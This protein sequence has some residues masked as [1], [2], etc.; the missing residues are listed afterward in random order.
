MTV[1]DPTRRGVSSYVAAALL[2]AA[3]SLFAFPPVPLPREA[4]ILPALVLVAE[5]IRVPLAGGVRLSFPLPFLA[6]IAVVG[7]PF[8]ALAVDVGATLVSGLVP[9][10]NPSRW[11]LLNM[12]IAAVSCGGSAAAFAILGEA[13]PGLSIAALTMLFCFFYAV[14]NTVLV[15]RVQGVRDSRKIAIA[16]LLRDSGG[17]LALYALMTV[18]VALFVEESNYGLVPLVLL[19]V[20]VLRALAAH[21]AKAFEQ[22]CETISALTMMLQRAHP[23][24]HGHIERVARISEDVA[25]RLG[26][27]PERARLVREASVLHDIGK[28]A[29]D[30]EILDKPAKLTETEMN[31]VRR[32]AAFGATILTP[33]EPFRQIVPWIRH[34]HERPDGRGYPAGL[35]D[36]EIPLESKIIAVVDAFDAM[37]GGD[38]P[39]ERRPYRK[40]MTPIQALAELQRCAGTQFDPTVV[41][42][43]REAVTS[44]GFK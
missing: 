18:S 1:V 44:G 21:R 2:V 30:E 39:S 3:A 12:S 36:A 17:V 23:Y 4:W 41:R 5:W 26:L 24:T 19:P 10:R 32:H 35:T 9:R 11:I 43:F 13:F 25:L 40:P 7:G 6:G 38:L 22:Y 16:K 20:T 37:A 33:I 8:W 29:I 34:H 27:S 42:A 15:A 31:H 14:T 28:I